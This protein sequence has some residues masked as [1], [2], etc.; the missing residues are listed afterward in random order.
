MSSAILCSCLEDCDAKDD[1]CMGYVK[2]VG[3]NKTKD[4]WV[5]LCWAHRDSRLLDG[6]LNMNLSDEDWKLP[7]GKFAP[8]SRVA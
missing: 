5:H 7:G 4:R 3:L 8:K 6:M 1:T 2:P